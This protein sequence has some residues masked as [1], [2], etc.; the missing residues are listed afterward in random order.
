MLEWGVDKYL[1]GLKSGNGDVE[2]MGTT[3]IDRQ[4]WKYTDSSYNEILPEIEELRKKYKGN[5]DGMFG[6]IS[7]F[8]WTFEAD[9]TYNIKLEI[10][11]QGDIIE[12]LKANLPPNNGGEKSPDSYAKI[13]LEQLQTEPAANVDQFYNDLYPGLDTLIEEWWGGQLFS[14]NLI[15]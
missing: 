15:V 5:Y 9:G 10:M 8:S 14:Y 1:D 2:S 13:R 11:S 3:L 7:N 12:S 6:V 4:F